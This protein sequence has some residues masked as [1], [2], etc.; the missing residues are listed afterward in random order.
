MAGPRSKRVNGGSLFIVQNS[1][2]ESNG[3]PVVGQKINIGYG[4]MGTAIG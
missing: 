4:S 2:S 1:V 3:S